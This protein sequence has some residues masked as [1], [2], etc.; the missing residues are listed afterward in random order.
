V[1]LDLAV[2]RTLPEEQQKEIPGGVYKGRP[3][4]HV[5]WGDFYFKVGHLV[6]DF[7]NFYFGVGPIVR[8]RV[9]PR[10]LVSELHTPLKRYT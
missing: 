9:V 5:V 10:N 3:N 2:C 7:L 6:W 4:R 1:R 8:S